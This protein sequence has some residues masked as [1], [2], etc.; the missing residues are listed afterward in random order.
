[1]E[2]KTKHFDM[3]LTPAVNRALKDLAKRDG[4]TKTDYLVNYVRRQAKKKGIPV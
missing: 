3:R 1:M 2:R 4:V